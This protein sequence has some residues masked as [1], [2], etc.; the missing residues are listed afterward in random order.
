MALSEAAKEGIHLSNFL[1]KLGHPSRNVISL[2]TDNSGARDLAYS[3]EHHERVKHIELRHFYIREMVKKHQHVVPYVSI[4][5]NMADFFTKPLSA[6]TYFVLR[7]R[8][9]NADKK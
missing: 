1:A 4:V 9:M 6:F 8:K 2:S 7:N 3:P 5:N